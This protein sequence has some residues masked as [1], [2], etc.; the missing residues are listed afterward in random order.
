MTVGRIAQDGVGHHAREDHR[1]RD[2]ENGDDPEGGQDSARHVTLRI[3]GLL[4]GGRD[5]VEPD[6]REEHDRGTGQHAV[7]A[8]VTAR[9]PGQQREQG[10]VGAT[11][12]L[13]GLVR[14]DERGV[15]GGLY[16][17]GAHD[18]HQEHDADLDL[19]MDSLRTKYGRTGHISE[20]L[21]THG[22]Y[23]GMFSRH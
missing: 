5:D 20:S 9:R 22:Y 19:A 3:T 17:E 16:I 1:H 6:E 12:T 13:P 10:L 15:I 18:H 2:I 23:K 4:G 11:G 14:R 7:P 21:G 8:V